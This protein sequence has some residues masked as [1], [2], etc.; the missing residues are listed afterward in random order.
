MFELWESIE[1][2]K[3]RPSLSTEYQMDKRINYVWKCEPSS[4]NALCYGWNGCVELLFIIIDYTTSKN[5][6][7]SRIKLKISCRHKIFFSLM[8]KYLAKNW[9]LKFFWSWRLEIEGA[10][11]IWCLTILSNVEFLQFYINYDE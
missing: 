6:L 8:K 5:L 4:F 9:F 3:T 1:K 10:R 2:L 11:F 7:L